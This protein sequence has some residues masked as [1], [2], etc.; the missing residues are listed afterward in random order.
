MAP[1]T[2]M[3]HLVFGS[4]CVLCREP[5]SGHHARLQLCP[6]CLASLPWRADETAP[7]QSELITGQVI[8]LRYEEPVSGW[9]IRAKRATG[10]VEA[11]VLGTLLADTLT[12]PPHGRPD[13][14][15]P[16]PL[17]RRRLLQRGHN[18]AAL[19]AAP[20]ARCLGIPM[21]RRGVRR[22]RHTAILAGSGREERRRR[23]AGAFHCSLNLTGMTVAIID[24]VVTTGTTAGE[25][26]GCL[27][28]AGARRVHLYAAAAAEPSPGAAAPSDPAEP[29]TL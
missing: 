12:V 15:V 18:Q 17:S 4:L 10:L 5:V 25:L 26:A 24:D 19:I 27:V 28:A 1:L 3:W 29:A 20:V 16:V 13:L 21:L 9:I 6:Y 2:R 23:V 8:P 14:L 7:A 11:N 22:V